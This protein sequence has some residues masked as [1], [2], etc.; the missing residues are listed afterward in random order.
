MTNLDS[1][2]TGWRKRLEDNLQRALPDA[3]SAPQTLHAAM[4]YATLDGGKRLRAC[5]VYMT[6]DALGADAESMDAPAAAVELIH[7]YSLV[8]DDLPCMDDDDLRRG[9]PSCH[10]AWNEATAMLVGDALQTLAFG[11]LAASRHPNTVNMVLTLAQASG[12]QG[13]AGGQA[14]DL[15]AI[16]K[17]LDIDAL[18]EIHTLKTGALISA[19]VT[20]GA[21]AADIDDAAIHKHLNEYSSS[22]GLGFQIRDDIL[23]I[24]G[25]TDT[26]GKQTGSD[27]VLDKP[28]YPILLG[29]SAAKQAAEQAR[30]HA[31]AA[32][33][34]LD[35][36]TRQ[37][38]A[39][40]DYV[41]NR[42]Y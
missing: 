22:I 20:L 4:R 27:A 26:L 36:D 23:D 37:L 32:L 16:G 38:A 19:A 18:R 7:A 35:A 17:T 12:S 3:D 29:M 13:M 8:H 1:Q 42:I 9:K 30:E 15:A 6:G 14:L 24:E 41:T 5:L 33:D 21:Q 10:K 25:D 39:L 40:A 11:I 34:K 28:T 31:L 2:L